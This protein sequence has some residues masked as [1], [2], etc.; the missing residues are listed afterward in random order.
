MRAR[1]AFL[2]AAGALFLAACGPRTS[3]PPVGDGAATSQAATT[4]KVTSSLDCQGQSSNSVQL[5]PIGLADN[6][7]TYQMV[8][9]Q[10]IEV[11][12]SHPGT[13]G[14]Q[15]AQ[16]QT[17]N[18][19]VLA[20]LPLPLPSPPPGGVNEAWIAKAPGQATLTSSL[21]CPGGVTTRWT[22]TFAVTA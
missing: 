21:A 13:D 15:W 1:T 4:Y 7:R 2:C 14:C 20:V 8:N 18:N 19:A 5:F 10:A 11:V 17:S 12:L 3:V 9:C 16:I 22:V 6:G